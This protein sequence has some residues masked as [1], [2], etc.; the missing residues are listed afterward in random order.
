MINFEFF[1]NKNITEITEHE[2]KSK[3]KFN[4]NI[5]KILLQPSINESLQKILYDLVPYQKIL[6]VSTSTPY[7][8]YGENIVDTILNAKNILKELKFDS[9]VQGNYGEAKRIIDYAEEDTKLIIVLGGGTVT[10]LAKFAADKLNIP[11]I[12]LPTT[13]SPS[14][15][16]NYALI[17]DGIS[18]KRNIYKTTVAKYVL[19]NTEILKYLKD[20]FTA[21]GYG[22]LVCEVIELFNMNYIKIMEQKSCYIFSKIAKECL[23][24]LPNINKNIC[25]GADDINEQILECLYACAIAKCGGNLTISDDVLTALNLNNSRLLGENMF[26]SAVFL[27]KIYKIFFLQKAFL[28]S[29]FLDVIEYLKKDGTQINFEDNLAVNT[30]NYIEQLQKLE[31]TIFKLVEFKYELKSEAEN[32]DLIISKCFKVFKRIYADSGFMALKSINEKM[33][34]QA[35]YGVESFDNVVTPLIQIK[36]FGLLQEI[37]G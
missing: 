13:L 37:C 29:N 30:Q 8:L 33:L 22:Q 32:L 11:L 15:C 9:K 25:A 27:S 17:T 18:E 6:L 1:N 19:V 20:N 34:K 31:I 3:C 16:L 4:S 10:D 5:P 35:L 7:N 14:A 23:S 24:L 21:S 12:V 28:Y 2:L 26:L 36:N